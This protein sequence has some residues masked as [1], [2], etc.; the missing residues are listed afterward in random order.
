MAVLM[1][2]WVHCI[3]IK[4]ENLLVNVKHKKIVISGI[5]LFEGG[6]L[7]IY[8]DFLN[9]LME[10]GILKSN[11][12]TI[13]VHKLQLFSE[14]KNAVKII[15]L[16]RSRENYIFRVYYEWFFFK[17][18]SEGK[19]IDYWI[20]LHDIT[21]RV[22][23]K[24][25][26]TYCH[27]PAPF[28]KPGKLDWKYS[29]RVC[30]FSLFY[31]YLYAINIKKN[32]G[33]I[34]Q[35][36]WMRKEFEKIYHVNN[37]IVARPKLEQDLENFDMDTDYSGYGKNKP[38]TFIYA[39][40][41]RTFKNFE[42]ICEACK[43]VDDNINFKVIFTIDGSENAY[44]KYLKEKY[45]HLKRIKWIGLQTREKL[46]QLYK[47]SD[48]MIFPS[49]L[50][51]WG[52]PISEYKRTGKPLILADLPYA[53]ETVGNYEKIVFFDPEHADELAKYIKNACDGI[54]DCFSEHKERPIKE[55]FV[56][57]WQ[58]LEELLFCKI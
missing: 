21:P 9:S 48:C 14:Y 13:F 54:L 55:P 19:N 58:E 30:M 35:Q 50:E 24:H 1:L 5:N 16:P 20:S 44:S 37:I 28:Y 7:S 53:H 51:T 31:K 42:I 10:C 15:E 23:A 43:L 57:C 26:F 27:N 12:V 2:I 29:K 18:Y 45:K 8:K 34:V 56:S 11:N 41:P 4:W 17:R 49:K 36:D 3:A 46:F 25:L 47:E 22:N 38:Y 6:A 32:E 39:S 33:I 52:L 40:L